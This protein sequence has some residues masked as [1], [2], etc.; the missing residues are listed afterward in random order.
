MLVNINRCKAFIVSLNDK[1][2]KGFDKGLMTD[3]ILIDIQKTFA[4]INHNILS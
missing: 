2:V 4:A 3:M 1:I